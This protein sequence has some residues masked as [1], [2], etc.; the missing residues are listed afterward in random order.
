V[1]TDPSLNSNQQ[2][3]CPDLNIFFRA[4]SIMSVLNVVSAI[5]KI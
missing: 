1:I 2:L 3:A 5:V 4:N